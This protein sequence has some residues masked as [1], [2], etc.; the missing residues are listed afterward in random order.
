VVAVTAQVEPLGEALS[1]LVPVV[2]VPVVL[3]GALLGA[4]VGRITG[5]LGLV[6]APGL[7]DVVGLV[8][9][10]GRLVGVRLRVVRGV[11]G[12][13]LA[14]VHELVGVG[15]G[16][17]G[18]DVDPQSPAADDDG[19]MQVDRVEGERVGAA[20]GPCS[21]VTDLRP[22]RRRCAG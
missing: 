6:D 5:V 17:L 4:L 9:F 20:G 21:A 2:L 8:V 1:L 7:V 19:A 14:Q 12:P 3:L 10:L 18:R 22:G 11:L 13:L 16:V 15:V